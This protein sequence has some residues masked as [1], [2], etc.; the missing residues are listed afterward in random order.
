MMIYKDHAGCGAAKCRVEKVQANVIS[1]ARTHIEKYAGQNI[2]G[3]GV[4]VLCLDIKCG[5]FFVGHLLSG[6]HIPIQDILN[7]FRW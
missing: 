1:N 4:D 5:D 3:L 7:S 2:T 6:I